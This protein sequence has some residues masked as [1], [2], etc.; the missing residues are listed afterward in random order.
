MCHLRDIKRGVTDG[1]PDRRA[2]RLSF[3]DAM[4]H[5]KTIIATYHGADGKV[6]GVMSIHV[7]PKPEVTEIEKW[8][9]FVRD[10]RWGRWVL[11]A[12]K[13][14]VSHHPILCKCSRGIEVHVI[15]L[16]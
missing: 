10:G 1:R 5:L 11:D 3:T 4:M 2:D 8:R 9:S 7:I 16:R 6:P 15:A 12:L 13:T 14:T